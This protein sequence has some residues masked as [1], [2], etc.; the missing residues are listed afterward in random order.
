[1]ALGKELIGEEQPTAASPAENP[2]KG[3]PAQPVKRRGR[4]PGT[5]QP[6]QTEPAPEGDQGEAGDKSPGVQG[7]T[8][9]QLQEVIKPLV[10]SGRGA[11]VKTT[12]QKFGV[13][14]LKELAEMPEKHSDFVTAIEA[15]SL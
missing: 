15:L 13:A 4:R 5:T 8:Y 11:E 12:I 7:M 14:A 10:T 6:A 2:A 1:V 9:E 3:D